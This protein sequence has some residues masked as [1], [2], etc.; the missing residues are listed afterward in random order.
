MRRAGILL[1]PTS[2]PGSGP[3]GDLGAGA[4]RFL[5]WLHEAGCTTWQV[6]PL[7]PPGGGFSPYDSPSAF[8]VGTHL[9]SLEQ[10]AEEG[11]LRPDEARWSGP[12]GD[13]VQ[14]DA[15]ESWHAPL[16]AR[17]AARF[18]VERPNDVE[19]FAAAH[20]WV[21][22]WALFRA[23]LRDKSVGSWTALSPGLRNR[24]PGTIAQ[25]RR[26]LHASIS[27]EIAAQALVHR[28]WAVLKQAAGDRDIEIVGDVPIFVSGGGADVWASRDLFRGGTAPDDPAA[29]WR[30]DPVTGVPP[31][32][33]SPTGQ[34]WGNPHY[35]W[36]RHRETHFAWW[37]ARFRAVLE[38][39]DVARVDHFRGFAAAWEIPSDAE[40]ATAGAWAAGPGRAL[41]DAVREGLGQLP[42]I[43]EDL[44]EIT[45][46]VHDLRDGLGLPGMK[47]LQFAFGGDA[48]HPFLPH[49]WRHPG[50]V[51]Y[52]G[53]HDNDTAM[54]WYQST[55]ER[56]RHRYRV[57]AQRDGSE[58]GWDLT[59]LAWSSIAE[60]AIA[61]LQDVLNLGTG[62]RFNTPG[63]AVGNWTWRA[64]SLPPTTAHR[65]RELAWATGR[66]HS[67]GR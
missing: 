14:V 6:L 42:L 36:D 61:P 67:S 59:R 48:H 35:A 38:L 62:A 1:H 17:A 63:T 21:R 40:D 5:D 13:L 29:T 30:A 54:G 18:A 16:V 22:D 34:R 23:L 45:D 53:T 46:D 44:G 52:T 32:Y 19:Q 4:V 58:P 24:H 9:L 8:A 64:T 25:A 3:C 55:S 26:R 60:R 49:N 50:W 27:Q 20:P 37:V 47:I 65:L 43:A 7:N 39:V 11:L 31:D 41:F 33:F 57:T 10:L 66:V 15:L 28:Q 51:A 12:R 2:L 56:A